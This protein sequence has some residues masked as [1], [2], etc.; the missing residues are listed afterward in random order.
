MDGMAELKGTGTEFPTRRRKM[1]Q[2]ED[3]DEDKDVPSG[4]II[5]EEIYWNAHFMAQEDG[6]LKN[7]ADPDLDYN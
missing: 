3:K 4:C 7:L 6:F 1:D 2:T 5:H